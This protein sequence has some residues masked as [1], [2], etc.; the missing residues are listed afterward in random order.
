ME[1]RGLGR[2]AT[3]GCQ[4][5]CLQQER[6]GSTRDVIRRDVSSITFDH[7]RSVTQPGAVFYVAFFLVRAAGLLFH[8][9]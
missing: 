9:F 7:I 5:S 2:L 6:K 1:R 8:V 3:N 4:V